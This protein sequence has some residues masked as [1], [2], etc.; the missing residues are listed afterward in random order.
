MTNAIDLEITDL[1]NNRC[2]FCATHRQVDPLSLPEI[3]FKLIKA[4]EENFDRIDLSGGEPTIHKDILAIVSS[5]RR[6]GFTTIYFK[7]NG[8]R[9]KDMDFA[10]RLLEMGANEFLVSFHGPSA[11][12]HDAQTE[13]PGSFAEA[14]E[15]TRNLVKLGANV[16]TLTVISTIN[17]QYLR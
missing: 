7:T 9:L 2:I 10:K 8:R 16:A 1:C 5:A 11:E 14:F 13:V 4:K 12:I 17:H 3:R 15:G 6:L